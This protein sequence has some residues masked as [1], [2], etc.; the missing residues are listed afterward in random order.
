MLSLGWTVLLMLLSVADLHRLS[1]DRRVQTARMFSNWQICFTVLTQ[2]LP[3]DFSYINETNH[4][5]WLQ[6]FLKRI[7]SNC[8]IFENAI[9]NLTFWTYLHTE[10][11]TE[12]MCV[13]L[14]WSYIVL[15]NSVIYY[16]SITFISVLWPLFLSL[17]VRQE[18]HWP[19][20]SRVTPRKRSKFHARTAEHK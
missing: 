7:L 13:I 16:F 8:Q 20:A 3:A 19:A 2:K 10:R 11:Y 9:A 5:G 15:Q 17:C 1:M 4:Q 6:Y 12:G 18:W 14:V